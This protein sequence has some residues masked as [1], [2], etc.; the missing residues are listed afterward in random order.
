M[1]LNSFM[2][3]GTQQQKFIQKIIQMIQ[4]GGQNNKVELAFM[5]QKKRKKISFKDIESEEE[6]EQT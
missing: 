1:E 3:N 5:E 4:A 2:V 6:S